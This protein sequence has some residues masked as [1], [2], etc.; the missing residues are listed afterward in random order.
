M[1]ADDEQST[2]GSQDRAL[3][4]LRPGHWEDAHGE[5]HS[6]QPSASPGRPQQAL[7]AARYSGLVTAPTRDPEQESQSS[8]QGTFGMRSSQ[9]SF[10]SWDSFPQERVPT[11][12]AED[13]AI[14]GDLLRTPPPAYSRYAE[15]PQGH[16]GH[17]YRSASPSCSGTETE[18]GSTDALSGSGSLTP[19]AGPSTEAGDWEP[20]DLDQEGNDF[21]EEQ[22]GEWQD[23]EFAE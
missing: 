18:Y 7:R 9:T 10:N 23:H 12:P 1:E 20:S 11:Q 16:A 21:D 13:Q 6:P 22:T 4:G 8:S 15:Q 2:A 5:I 3:Q 17:A 19:T 14:D